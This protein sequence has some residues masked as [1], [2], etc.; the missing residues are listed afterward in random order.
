MKLFCSSCGL[1]QPEGWE[2][3]VCEDCEERYGNPDLAPEQFG[4]TCGRDLSESGGLCDSCLGDS[5]P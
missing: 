1:E 4:N 5:L 3:E 2:G